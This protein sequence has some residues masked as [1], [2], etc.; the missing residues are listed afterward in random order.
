VLPTWAGKDKDNE[1]LDETFSFN[2]IK[3][4]LSPKY[5]LVLDKT[6][7]NE[8][9][10]FI[11]I[12]N[13]DTRERTY[14][15]R[16][17]LGL[18]G[19]G[20]LAFFLK[21]RNEEQNMRFWNKNYLNCRGYIDYDFHNETYDMKY[22]EYVLPVFYVN[23]SI[24][25]KII[26]NIDDYTVDFYLKQQYNDSIESYN[27]IG[28]LNGTDPSKT[29]IIG[30]LYDSWW[31]PG[32]TDSAIGMAIVLGI[33]KYFTENN[34]T[35]KYNVKFIGFCG[36]EYGMRGSKHYEATHKDENIIYMIDFNQLGFIQEDPRPV[37]EIAA[38]NRRFLSDIWDV[39]QETNYKER[40]DDSSD[41]T[42][43][44][45]PIGHIS[46]DRS[47]ASKRPK[48]KTI[49][50]LKNNWDLHHRC[51]MNYSEGDVLK[52]FYWADVSATGEIALNI[53][54]YIII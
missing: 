30:C 49:C 4:I 2:G 20:S 40:I 24:G 45:M 38:N 43:K 26:D 15:I 23:G 44:Y 37:L 46:D 27:V 42:P 33:A 31:C 47:F 25:K 8:E 11:F 10:D 18:V 52:Y 5:P 34:I 6:L 48:C 22:R 21:V 12:K 50:F 35:P 41:I 7:A 54:K 19:L 14:L 36:E 1:D 39:A 32:T 13:P 3:V 53:I 16:K 51:G 9:E 29:V 28:Q 17:F